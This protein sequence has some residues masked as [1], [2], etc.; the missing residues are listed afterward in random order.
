MAAGPKRAPLCSSCSARSPFVAKAVFVLFVGLTYNSL[1]MAR[2]RTPR[3]DTQVARVVAEPQPAVAW[4]AIAIVTA[5]F[6]TY[7]N[8]LAGPFVFDDQLSIV[9]N[10]SIR[11]WWQPGIV[12]FPER[13]LPVAGRPLVNFSFALNYA[14]GGLD[15][16]GYHL[17]NIALHLMCALLVFGLVRRTLQMPIVNASL[18]QQSM[19]VAFAVALLWT[20]HPLTTEAVNY[21]TQRT[22]LMMAFFYL[23]T[24]YA[25]SRAWRHRAPR[26][27]HAVAIA[28]CAAGMAC[29]ESM[30]T[31]P[32]MVVVY[33]A[34]FLVGSLKLALAARWRFYTGLALS[35]ALL[36][37]LMWSGPRIHSAGFSSGVSPWTYLLN[38]TVM[39][40][41]YLHLSVWPRS[42]VANYGWPVAVTLRE[43]FPYALFIVALLALTIAA[44][45][46]RPA[47]GFLGA[48]FFITLAPT[49]SI[50]PIATEVGAERRIYLPLIAVIVLAVVSLS[51]IKV[52]PRVA[53]VALLA[54]AA[55][56]AAGTV[57]R[58]RD[59]RSALQLARTTVERWPT[60]VARH[61]LG[62]EL[63]NAGV[64]DE[65]MVHLRQAVDGAPRARYTLGVQLLKQG[66]TNAAIDELRHFLREQPLLLEAVPARQL[67]GQ[68]L[69]QQ[70]QWPQAIEQYRLVLTMNPTRTQ[71]LE[72]QALLGMA[73]VRA[74]RY[75]EA[76][77]LYR[78][79]LEERPGDIEALSHAGIALLATNSLDEGLGAFRRAVELDPG[80]GDMRRN[81]AA[82]LF[83]RREIEEAAVHAERAVALQPADATARDLFGRILAVQGD[84]AGARAQFERALQIAPD[85]PDAREDLAKLERLIASRD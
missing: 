1:P 78:A 45:I 72:T 49:S 36:L 12:L 5:G 38:Q 6:L 33:D 37:A 48:W 74:E 32:V 76:V 17:V 84:F 26:R 2:S 58:N 18:R 20:L 56:L 79:Y 3:K 44:L 73:L 59:Y 15:V 75:E 24:L 51:R 27:W 80:N 52:P 65:A 82:A 8:S 61:V 11:R 35:W 85:D 7:A 46:R 55:A 77:S 83:D 10:A 41:Q 29:K 71:R 66:E 42:L 50:V 60:S 81:L 4:L 53:A 31:A 47:F 25:S 67:L 57:T 54:C 40:T 69:A 14:V 64:T 22:E 43:V 39:I 21:V 23:L 68:A 30:V 16:F 28:S 63:L 70:Q 9:E 13:E 19:N 34:I 62:T